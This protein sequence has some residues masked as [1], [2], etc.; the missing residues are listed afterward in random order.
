[1][2]RSLIAIFA[3]TL[4]LASGA[5]LA[6]APSSK[7]YLR[8]DPPQP[9][10]PDKIEVLEFFWYGCSHCYRLEPSL[11]RWSKTLPKDVVFKRVP[12]I[13]NEA[14]GQTAIYFYTLEAMGLLDKYHQKVFDAIH[15]DN[16]NL[17]NRKV[18]DEWLAK[19]GI[20]VAEFNKVAKSFSVQAKMSRAKQLTSAYKISGVPALFVAGKYGTSNELAGG[21]DQVVQVTDGLV[22]M[23]RREMAPA[24]PAAPAAATAKPAAAAPAKPAAAK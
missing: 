17:A 8:V 16:L 22:G 21:P 12:A 18:G 24:A 20:D 5:T 3:A 14:W 19:Q 4:A 11:V 6:Q 10:E 9:T 2:L 1:M 13:P 7:E 23:A 15:Q